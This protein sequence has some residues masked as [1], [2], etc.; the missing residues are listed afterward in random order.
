MAAK[1]LVDKSMVVLKKFYEDN[2][3]SLAQ[4][5]VERPGSPYIDLVQSEQPGEAPPPPPPT[6][7]GGYGGAKGESNGIQSIME[8]IK[9][10]IDKDIRDATTVEEASQ[11]EFDDFK[12][13]QDAV[14]S[15]LEEQKATLEEEVGDVEEGI[16]I[17]KSKRD[18]K[19]AQLDNT[20]G[21]LRSIAPECD[22]MNVNFQLRK[23]NR[24]AEIDGLLEAKAALSGA[25]FKD[26]KS[27]VAQDKAARTAPAGFLQQRDGDRE[28]C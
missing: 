24:A 21:F 1:G 22:F 28:E 7:E 25:S 3:L 2:G 13:D 20:M 26:Q 10:D 8:M 9:D 15:S 12:A 17:S 23:D 5:T 11:K 4:A 18:E 27:A 14:I 16:Y 19:K 6:W